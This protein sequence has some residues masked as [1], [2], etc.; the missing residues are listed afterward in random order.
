MHDMTID[1]A[2]AWRDGYAAARGQARLL[3]QGM[4][5]KLRSM[6][7][8]SEAATLETAADALARM[9]QT[10]PVGADGLSYRGG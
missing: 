7:C 9:Q 3:L 4:A 8:P 5:H 1:E 2:A 6:G 10:T